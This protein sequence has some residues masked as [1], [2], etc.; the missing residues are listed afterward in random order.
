MDAEQKKRLT[1]GYN[2]YNNVTCPNLMGDPNRG[3]V[4]AKSA[5]TAVSKNALSYMMAYPI[6]G[7]NTDNPD[8]KVVPVK[9]MDASGTADA[10]QGHFY[11]GSDHALGSNFF[12]PLG[13]CSAKSKDRD[14][15]GQDRWIY[16]RNIPTGK[17]PLLGNISFHDLTGCNM[18]G[19]TEG[20]GLVPGLL[21]DISDISPFNIMEAVGGGGNFGSH[22]CKRK[23]YPIGKNIYDP[24]MEC[25]GTEANCKDKMWQLETRCTPSH[26]HLKRSTKPKD[27]RQYPGALSF[28]GTE[29]EASLVE[30]FANL[31]HHP[32]AM[33]SSR[34]LPGRA[35]VGAATAL[36]V[37]LL[38]L[39]AYH[40]GRRGHV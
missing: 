1:T 36:G 8:G 15:R 30:S 10:A 32:V 5:I 19:I 22:D 12:V 13:K 34:R 23:T 29:K 3:E 17:I 16:V 9:V 2:I 18:E 11:A 39:I 14:C 35:A 26:H 27:L 28:A 4:T 40:R 21:E 31:A 20:R 33:P 24:A 7:V 38:L 6:A 37:L 25:T